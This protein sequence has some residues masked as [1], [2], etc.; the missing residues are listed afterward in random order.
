MLG[1]QPNSRESLESCSKQF[2]KKL[3]WGNRAFLEPLVSDTDPPLARLPASSGCQGHLHYHP[4]QTSFCLPEY[5]QTCGLKTARGKWQGV[6]L[7]M[8][9]HSERLQSRHASWGWHELGGLPAFTRR[10]LLKGAKVSTLKTCSS[11]RTFDL[12][13][14]SEPSRTLAGSGR[15]GE[16][17]QQ[18]SE[19]TP[20]RWGRRALLPE[21][22]AARRP[23]QGSQGTKC[24]RREYYLG[25]AKSQ[26]VSWAH[27]HI[28]CMSRVKPI[29]LGFSRPLISRCFMMETNSLLLSSPLPEGGENTEV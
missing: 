9:I 7:L 10:A 2:S 14:D 25:R 5:S 3:C 13:T 19:V 11:F 15:G 1:E 8:Q 29:S 4:S 18:S 28:A 6:F 23:L 12:T 24:R 21:A 16:V 20:R 22:A 17:S 26:A 27:F